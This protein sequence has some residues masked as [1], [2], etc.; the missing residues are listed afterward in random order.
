MRRPPRIAARAGGAAPRSAS[1]VLGSDHPLARATEALDSVVRQSLAVAAVLVGSSIDLMAGRAWAATLAASADRRPGGTHRDR[2]GM[3]TEP[4]RP[5]ARSDSRGP[6]QRPSRRRAASAPT[7]PGPADANDPGPKPRGDNRSSVALP[8]T[9]SLQDLSAVRACCDQGGRGG[10]SRDHSTA[11]LRAGA[12]AWRRARRAPT[13]R[14]LL[15]AV[16]KPSR[17]AAGRAPPYRPPTHRMSCPQLAA[18]VWGP[19]RQLLLAATIQPPVRG[20]H[21]TRGSGDPVSPAGHKPIGGRRESSASLAPAGRVV[22][23]AARSSWSCARGLACG[24]D[25]APLRV[26]PRCRVAGGAGRLGRRAVAGTWA[27]RSLTI[28][29]GTLCSGCLSATSSPRV[30]ARR[31]L[32]S[33]ISCCA[34]RAWWLAVSISTRSDA[35]LSAVWPLSPAMNRDWI[36]ALACASCPPKWLLTNVQ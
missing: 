27:C 24:S 30:R 25:V 29:E 32:R 7:P 15:A 35:A 23:G 22:M 12:G 3:Q 5:C 17:A 2:R 18:M 1:A 31:V 8:R 34:L 26:L 4:T 20:R 14:R 28:A 19:P 33:R 36:S 16:R 9:P 11:R 6:R 21:T 13:H 10:S